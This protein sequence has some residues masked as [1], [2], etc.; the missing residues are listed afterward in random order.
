LGRLVPVVLSVVSVRLSPERSGLLNFPV[1]ME[2]I[3]MVVLTLVVVVVVGL[4]L[5]GL[6]A[7]LLDKRGD[8]ATVGLVVL[9]MVVQVATSALVLHRGAHPMAHKVDTAE[10]PET[11]P[12]YGKERSE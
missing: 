3:P 11:A 1:G 8:S 4:V 12:D 10:V 5:G 9:V 2:L 6:A 7:T